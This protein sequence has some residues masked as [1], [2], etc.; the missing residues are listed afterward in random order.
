MDSDRQLLKL[1]NECTG[2]EMPFAYYLGIFSELCESGDVGEKLRQGID[3]VSLQSIV[4]KNSQLFHFN[5]Q[6]LLALCAA[7]LRRDGLSSDKI[8]DYVVAS[9]IA[10][11]IHGILAKNDEECYEIHCSVIL[12][13]KVIVLACNKVRFDDEAWN[14]LYRLVYCY[15]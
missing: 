8:E 7:K 15:S 6:E 12:M 14:D 10:M 5:A 9:M 3:S 11:Y 13:S 4:I 2:S 1:I